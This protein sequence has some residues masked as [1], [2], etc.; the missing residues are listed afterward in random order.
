VE[1]SF[2]AKSFKESFGIVSRVVPTR[3]VRPILQSVKVIAEQNSLTL[4]ASDNEISIR[5]RLE[6]TCEVPGVGLLPKGHVESI[7]RVTEGETLVFRS[8]GNKLSIRSAAGKWNVA[9]EDPATFPDVPEFGC[10]IYH[11]LSGAD[12]KRL[13]KRTIYAVDPDSTRYALGGMLC[14]GEPTTIRLAATDAKVFALQQVPASFSGGW[15]DPEKQRVI[16][17]TT[18]N[19]LSA[20]LPDGPMDLGFPDDNSVRFRSGGLTVDSRLVYGRFP[21]W[22]RVVPPDPPFRVSFPV[23]PFRRAVEQAAVFRSEDSRCLSLS[24]SEGL[25]SIASLSV[26]VGDT[27]IE[28]SVEWSA[29]PLRICVDS[30][31]LLGML[32]AFD[33]DVALTFGFT[34]VITNLRVESADGFLGSI[35][36]MIQ[37]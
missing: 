32:R 26:D 23:G 37:G 6:T 5:L 28:Y 22:S 33:D 12:Y 16:P 10:D 3:A 20:L 9:T 27:A 25:L 34:D 14:Q 35:A 30:L 36:L 1:F 31:Y 24:F 11:T 17:H 18:Q 13:V 29:A 19:V 8:E 15:S 2:P 4:M 7:L 21:G